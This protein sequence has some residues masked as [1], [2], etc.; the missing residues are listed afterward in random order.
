MSALLAGALLDGGS[1][2]P[3]PAQ[4]GKGQGFGAGVPAAIIAG[5]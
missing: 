2:V 4:F 3:L 1:Y 5:D